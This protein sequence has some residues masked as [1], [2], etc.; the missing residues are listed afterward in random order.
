[1]LAADVQLT[2]RG[3]VKPD[4]TYDVEPRSAALKGWWRD[5]VR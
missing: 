3:T 4:G 2:G 1:V 5:M